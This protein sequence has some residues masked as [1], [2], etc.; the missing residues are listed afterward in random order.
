[1]FPHKKLFRGDSTTKGR[2]LIGLKKKKPVPISKGDFSCQMKSEGGSD[3]KRE[4]HYNRK[5]DHTFSLQEGLPPRKKGPG[6]KKKRGAF[7]HLAPRD[8]GEGDKKRDH[9]SGAVKNRNGSGGRDGAGSH[10]RPGRRGKNTNPGKPTYSGG[11]TSFE[12][13]ETKKKKKAGNV[14]AD[15][16][17]ENGYRRG[18][19][20][21]FKAETGPVSPSPA[22]KNSGERW[23]NLMGRPA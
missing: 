17:Q 4:K 10:G 23:G 1:L 7:R 11:H 8:E 12:K 18:E 21:E 3:C 14:D 22:E 9:K 13:K 5:C 19:K 16:S 6:E 20:K 2:N 15:P